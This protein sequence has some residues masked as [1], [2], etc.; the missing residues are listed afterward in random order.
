MVKRGDIWL[1]NL[2]P[3]VGSEIKKTRPC[4]VVSPPE[5]NKHLRTVM[6]APM[7][8]KGFDAPFRP[9]LTF[10]G[11]QGRILLDQLRAVDKSRFVKKLGSI[12]SSTHQKVIGVLQE[13]FAA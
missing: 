7:T 10:Q 9:Q 5:L 1:I 3:T 4:V 6:V 2:D 11:T 8:S 13:I 12:S